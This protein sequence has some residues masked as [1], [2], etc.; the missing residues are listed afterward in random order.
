MRKKYGRQQ[1]RELRGQESS[2]TV[3]WINKNPKVKVKS[4]IYRGQLEGSDAVSVWGRGDSMTSVGG[5]SPLQSH[6][7]PCALHLS[8]SPLLT[9]EG[10]A[11]SPVHLGAS[12]YSV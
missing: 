4:K 3:C 11:L 7:L 8:L 2:S 9:P 5:Q 12:L 6:A 1:P 10:Q